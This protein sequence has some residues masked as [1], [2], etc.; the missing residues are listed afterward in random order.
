MNLP[1]AKRLSHNVASVA[2]VALGVTFFHACTYYIPATLEASRSNDTLTVAL[3]GHGAARWDPQK[4]SLIIECESCASSASRIVEHF[5]REDEAQYAI[6]NTAPLTL[7][8][9]SL[10]H[11]E[12]LKLAGTGT[13]ATPAPEM[14]PLH[15]HHNRHAFREPPEAPT[16]PAAASE[17]PMKTTKKVSMVK[18]TAA[19]GVA[20]YSD[21]TK[22]TVLKI[23]PQGTMLTLLSKEGN[24][25]SVSVDGQEGF[26]DAEAV[27]EQ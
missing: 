4:D 20:I 12:T 11:V 16:T 7:T 21:K 13:L 5:S 15:I 24:L 14:R 6:D 22:T 27:T 1:K 26:I 10:G 17:E 19:E 25:Y 9:Y 2:L 23:V 3:A 8:L 18:V